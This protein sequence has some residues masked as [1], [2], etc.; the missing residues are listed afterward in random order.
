[1][2][3]G[4]VQNGIFV[5]TLAINSKSKLEKNQVQIDREKLYFTQT[6]KNVF[7]I[8]IFTFDFGHVCCIVIKRVG[9][10]EM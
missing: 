6:I 8:G 9:N 2:I 4:L 3:F 10:V 7:E 5:A 1:M